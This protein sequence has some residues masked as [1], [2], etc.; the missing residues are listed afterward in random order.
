M[1][2]NAQDN[3]AIISVTISSMYVIVHFYP[4][5]IVSAAFFKAVML[6]AQFFCQ[7]AGMLIKCAVA[8][9]F[10]ATGHC[11]VYAAPIVFIAAEAVVKCRIRHIGAMNE[12]PIKCDSN[13]RSIHK[14][15][16]PF[17]LYQLS[18]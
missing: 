18:Q 15:N 9:A 14:F 8:D 10:A 4:G 12:A 6:F 13:C 1:F 7:E 5:N 2:P 3:H 16:C 17:C 11:S